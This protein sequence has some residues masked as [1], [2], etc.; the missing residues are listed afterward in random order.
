MIGTA[1]WD[2]IEHLQADRG[3]TL[4]FLGQSSPPQDEEYQTNL[5]IAVQELNLSKQ[6]GSRLHVESLI[7]I[8]EFNEL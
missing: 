1:K 7:Y 5:G 6:G 3:S 2:Y 4:H 8:F